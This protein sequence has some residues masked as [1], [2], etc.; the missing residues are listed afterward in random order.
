M[1]NQYTLLLLII[2]DEV[3]FCAVEGRFTSKASQSLS[4]TLQPL[5]HDA[6]GSFATGSSPEEL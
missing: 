4:L 3:L 6:N 5:F 1:Y 2:C